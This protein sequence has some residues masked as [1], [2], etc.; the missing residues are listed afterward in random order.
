VGA[1]RLIGAHQPLSPVIKLSIR[2]PRKKEKCEKVRTIHE[3][4]Y[5]LQISWSA[6]R[7][8]ILCQQTDKQT[9]QL[10][11]SGGSWRLMSTKHNKVP[12]PAQE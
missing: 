5:K 11:G 10:Q 12:K 6:L 1:W 9:N 3:N 8:G 4:F 2:H 7:S